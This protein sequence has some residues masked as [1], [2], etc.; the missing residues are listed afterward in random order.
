MT[1]PRSCGGIHLSF[2]RKLLGIWN[3]MIFAILM[4]FAILGQFS[5]CILS[6]SVRLCHLPLPPALAAD[7][8]ARSKLF[9]ERFTY[10][11]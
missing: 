3:S 5:R 7:G 11:T 8:I 4:T 1:F 2:F 10:R 9:Q 6:R